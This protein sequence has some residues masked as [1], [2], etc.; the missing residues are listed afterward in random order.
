MH[1]C[2]P[3][4]GEAV[5]ATRYRVPLPGDVARASND[6]DILRPDRK[7][8]RERE[9][10]RF[11]LCR[12]L[13]SGSRN[14]G[15][16]AGPFSLLYD[17]VERLSRNR[18]RFNILLPRCRKPGQTVQAVHRRN[19]LWSRASAISGLVDRRESLDCQRRTLG[20]LGFID[21][22]SRI[23]MVEVLADPWTIRIS[24]FIVETSRIFMDQVLKNPWTC[25]RSSGSLGSIVETSGIIGSIVETSGFR[26]SIVGSSRIFMMEVLENPWTINEDLQDSLDSL[27]EPRE[28]LSWRS[29]KIIGLLTK[30]FRIPWIHC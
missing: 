14:T 27:L 8:E 29:S 2:E 21:G 13:G 3:R 6:D 9:G 10:A 20:S 7:R 4:H 17:E 30:I 24:G 12:R 22:T 11:E 15:S 1:L 28:F 5:R 16:P 18:P 23:F 25:G 19:G 26:G